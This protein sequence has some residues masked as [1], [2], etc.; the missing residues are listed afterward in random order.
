MA[1]IIPQVVTEERASGAQVI[2][3]STYFYKDA[4]DYLSKQYGA[5]GNRTTWTWSA[6]V[7]R[8]FSFTTWRRLW[9]CEP[10]GSNIAGISFRGSGSNL[11]DAIRV[12][13]QSSGINNHATTNGVFRDTNGWY[14]IVVA[15]DTTD[16]NAGDRLKIYV[17]GVEETYQWNTGG[18]PA[19]NS[20]WLY[21][22]TS[23]SHMIGKSKAHDAQYHGW[24]S[25]VY[26]IDGQ[27]LGPEH[28]GF[29][30][31]LTK[32]WRPKK[33][34][35]TY[36]QNGFYLP[37][38]GNKPITEDQSGQGNNFAMYGSLNTVP[39]DKATGGLPIYNTTGGGQNASGGIRPD[40]GTRTCEAV[41]K[42]GCTKFDG[43]GDYLTFN[44]GTDLNIGTNDF[45][46]EAWVFHTGGND[47]T[48]ISDT[49]GWTFTYGASGN[50]R[51][52]MASGSNAVDATSSFISN[53]WVHVA[54]VR[55]SN[56]LTFY[57]NGVAV[58]SHSYSHTIANN[59]TSTNIGKYHS[60]TTQYWKGFISNL[61]IVNG[62]AAYLSNFTPSKEPLTNITNTKLLCCCSPITAGTAL[63]APT[64]SGVNNG[65][66][67]SDY[68][69]GTSCDHSPVGAFDGHINNTRSLRTAANQATVYF[70]PP[71]EITVNT[72]VKV[73]GETGYDS[74]C[75]ITKGDGTTMT[76]S[77]GT[78]HTFTYS[79]TL[80]SFKITGNDASGRTY[81][82]G[83]LIDDVGLVDPLVGQSNE[84]AT[85]SAAS[86]SCTFAVPFIDSGNGTSLGGLAGE[87][88]RQINSPFGLA[89]AGSTKHTLSASN[90]S[91][92]KDD[93]NFYCACRSFNGSSS[94]VNIPSHADFDIG[95][96]DF[97]VEAWVNHKGTAGRTGSVILNKSNPGGTSNSSFY[98]GFGHNGVS[99]YLDDSGSSWS[100]W[101]EESRTMTANEWYHLT[102]QRKNNVLQ[103]YI[104]GTLAQTGSVADNVGA[105]T[106][107]RQVN[108]GTQD[109]GGSWYNGWIQDLRLYKNYAK[110]DGDF[111]V[112]STVPS[113]TP[114]S[115]S[116]IVHGTQNIKPK[117]G[118]VMFA[119]AGHTSGVN[120]YL[121]AP[122]NAA[123][124]PNSN[125]FCV[126]Y[127][128][129]P[130]SNADTGHFAV[131]TTASLWIGQ[132][133]ISGQKTFVLRE[134][135]VHNNIEVSEVP[136]PDKW[137]HVVVTRQGSVSRVFFDGVL[138]GIDFDDN[139]NYLSGTLYLGTDN[140]YYDCPG[141]M[142]NV[143]YCRLSVPAEYR[144]G[145]WELEYPVFV[146][147]TE[148]L[149][150]T[151][152]GAVASD[153]QL[154]CCQDNTSTT[155]ATKT[156]S[157]WSVSDAD[158][159]DNLSFNPFDDRS[160]PATN[161]AT[162]ETMNCGDVGN[163][164]FSHGNLRVDN[165]NDTLTTIGVNS[166]KWYWEYKAINTGS[167]NHWGVCTGQPLHNGG[168]NTYISEN[169]IMFWRK[170]NNVFKYDKDDVTWT[171]TYKR[172]DIGLEDM[173]D[174]VGIALDMDNGVV[175]SFRE[176]VR[177]L[178]HTFTRH[179]QKPMF[180]F[181]RNNTGSDTLANFGQTAFKFN[182]PHDHLP[183]CYANLPD[184]AVIHPK[185]DYF[186]AKT[187][188]G[189]GGTQ[190]V[191]T[192]FAPDLVWMK[193][194]TKS[195]SNDGN[196]SVWDSVRG[197]YR[198]RFL[199]DSSLE[200]KDTNGLQV[201]HDD[202]WTTGSSARCNN[203]GDPFVSYNWK[204]GGKKPEIPNGG[205]VEFQSNTIRC[206]SSGLP[207][208]SDS[209]TIEFW[210]WIEDGHNAWQNLFSHGNGVA[211]GCF[212]LNVSRTDSGGGGTFAFTG[213]S[214]GD[215][216]IGLDNQD[217]L[218]GWRHYALTY[219]GT[220][221]E[222]FLDG[223]SKG[224]SNETLNTGGTTFCIG[225]SEHTGFGENFKGKISNFRVSDNVRYTSNFT[226]PADPYVTDGNTKLLCCQDNSDATVAVTKPGTLTTH[227]TTEVNHEGPFNRFMKDGKAYSTTGRAGLAS[228]DIALT[229]CSINTKAG[230]AI[231]QFNGNNTD[232]QTVPH[233]LGVEPSMVF[234]MNCSDGGSGN[235]ST[236]IDDCVALGSEKIIW[237]GNGGAA[238]DGNEL[239][240]K[241]SNHIHLGTSSATNQR[242]GQMAYVWANIPGVQHIGK[243]RGN[244]GN[245]GLFIPL[246][247]KPQLLIIKRED[248]SGPWA[249]NDTA[250]RAGDM[251]NTLY[252]ND[253]TLV[254]G[255]DGTNDE[256]T[257]AS[258]NVDFLSNG[259][260][261][262][263]NNA[264]YNGNAAHYCYIAFA[265]SNHA[266]MYGGQ[267]TAV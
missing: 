93:P 33:Y 180:P 213:Y 82:E 152:Q 265:E 96:D 267:G 200:T 92:N 94:L 186:L 8:G 7:K 199:N 102:W 161:F 26:W 115:P 232:A 55:S 131:S 49:T 5:D 241:S 2:D 143:R 39:L 168:S 256:T 165:G 18:N 84:F 198:N 76:S 3:G 112:A 201:F 77:S 46:V 127:F 247:F 63:V 225:G 177:V 258:L 35:G 170:D 219:N 133:E 62:S 41:K 130:R 89:N 157:S 28:F 78:L 171:E 263:S 24:M 145:A 121:T 19:Q 98:F 234:S 27:R 25:Q 37:L 79:G 262:R 135:G 51:F 86:G 216:A 106:S 260:K 266:S 123:W 4:D 242:R 136:A 59:S 70:Y 163:A 29:D 65:T 142:S 176:G 1:V 91:K 107:T 197:R 117:S 119:G 244:G 255:A 179:S 118:S 101:I 228:S 99:L 238:A 160:Y 104:N 221:V 189:N 220:T 72:S 68:M 169:V 214:T 40:Y 231:L 122:N 175:E 30:D 240:N 178:R 43:D 147:P 227:G 88:S 134:W 249:F 54:V 257:S 67:W 192:G 50:L 126:E 64:V 162:W 239:K 222:F 243:Y 80:K 22:S 74:T 128:I 69:G 151:S 12:Q 6:W 20:T 11:D 172:S 174:T 44:P 139:N 103:I 53:E 81:V 217:F 211:G 13:Q 164:E 190:K 204:A 252:G 158:E 109:S 129:Y 251:V 191:T 166:G 111:T 56:T 137:T 17:N 208:G 224:T 188:T 150:L 90:T 146:P 97:T 10:D 223:V 15:V 184:P 264:N 181:I 153:V 32:F 83:V 206:T 210:A 185:E 125:D 144:T 154:L 42:S 48:I 58:G 116:G 215:W 120:A 21:N 182:I 16:A 245:T 148:P 253:L 236:W 108:I 207:T 259:F 226:P 66:R 167:V 195:G 218:N 159:V 38:D 237:N 254:C 85:Y 202:G 31:P 250:R 141:A 114:E 194:R 47:D 149:T 156:A 61:R 173:G 57:Q 212:G 235:M 75:V 209:R 36:G 138:K 71:H 229:G 9:T 155:A 193:A 45:T 34:S 100:H 261:L 124:G 60:G 187:Y 203:N 248:N 95:T 23:D 73:Q 105:W 52:Y 14:H 230:F 132:F 110:Y 113:I 233:G 87:V 196:W 246:S 183:L 205:C 140:G